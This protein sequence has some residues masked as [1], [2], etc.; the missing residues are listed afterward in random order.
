MKFFSALFVVLFSFL[1]QA[2]AADLCNRT[3][4]KI[5]FTNHYTAAA[6]FFG[7]SVS[8]A[9][10]HVLNNGQCKNIAADN[11]QQDLIIAVQKAGTFWGWST[12]KPSSYKV[13]TRTIKASSGSWEIYPSQ[14]YICIPPEGRFKDRRQWVSGGDVARKRCNGDDIL[15]KNLLVIKSWSTNFMPRVSVILTPDGAFLR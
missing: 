4:S 1:T 2:N 3:G 10:W 12:L 7:G 13:E 5:R 14:S 9:G 8:F 11:G 15:E 6:L